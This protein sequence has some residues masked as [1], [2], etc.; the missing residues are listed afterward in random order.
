MKI[1][2]LFYFLLILLLLFS[3][4]IYANND[5]Y[6][7]YR[8]PHIMIWGWG[9]L[10]IGFLLLIFIGLIIYLIVKSAKTTTTI[11]YNETNKALNILN[12]RYVKGEVNEKEYRRIKKDLQDGKCEKEDY[13]ILKVI[14][15]F[16]CI[17][18]HCGIVHLFLELFNCIFNAIKKCI[19]HSKNSR[20][21]KNQNEQDIFVIIFFGVLLL[22]LCKFTSFLQNYKTFVF[23]LLAWRVLEILA[24]QSSI[25]VENV[26]S[27]PRSIVLFL[28]NLF[29]VIS[30]FAILYLI[31][32]A[33]GYCKYKAIQK[34]FEALYFSILTISTAGSGD[35]I[36]INSYGKNLVFFETV[37]GILLLVIFFGVL[38]SSK[39]GRFLCLNCKNIDDEVLTCKAF[40]KGIPKNILLDKIKHKQ[41]IKGQ[42]GEY[43]FEPKDC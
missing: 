38:I 19:C 12:E 37:I 20:I 17:L 15:F 32:G 28:I 35:I 6:S 18:T 25:I 8:W 36:P 23:L 29:E 33:I 3:I 1:F 5:F 11:V 22:I 10:F 41:I 21:E 40:P 34:P 31:Y 24:Y 39:E 30:I 42:T 43:V 13:I 27:V 16:L 4:D 2:R 14:K 7:L 9:G 26:A